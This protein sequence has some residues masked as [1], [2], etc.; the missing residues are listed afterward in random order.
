MRTISII[1]SYNDPRRALRCYGE[2]L[3]TRSADHDVIILDNS[4]KQD[5]PQTPDTVWLG[6]ENVHHGGMI[7]HV[8]RRYAEG[9]YDFVGMLNCDTWGFRPDFMEVLQRHME[10]DVGIISPAVLHGSIWPKMWPSPTGAFR[11]TNF[12]ETIAP[13]YNVRL[14]QQMR[15]LMPFERYGYVDRALSVFSLR[16]GFVNRLVDATTIYHDAGEGMAEHAR[17]DLQLNWQ[18]SLR[19]WAQD[20]PAVRDLCDVWPDEI[21]ATTWE[22]TSTV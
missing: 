14:L 13:Y 21:D 20:R 5:V 16:C 12:I 18:Q 11:T 8:V 4:R 2:L 9:D 17:H 6:T 15:E 1:F 3:R 7:D 19:A 10:P 22:A